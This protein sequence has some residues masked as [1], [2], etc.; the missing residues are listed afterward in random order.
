V[1]ERVPLD[2][3]PLF[4]DAARARNKDPE[5]SHEAARQASE[6]LRASQEAVLRFFR[7]RRGRMSD[8]QL[9]EEYPGG[10]DGYPEQ[11]PSGLRTRRHELVIAGKIVFTGQ[12]DTFAEGKVKPRIWRLASEAKSA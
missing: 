10:K 5:T 7:E 9:V 12:R 3:L 6:H 2:T 1:S 4:A 11:S 8:Q